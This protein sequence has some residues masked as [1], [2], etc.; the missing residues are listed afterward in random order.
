MIHRDLKPDNFVIGRTPETSSHLYLI[1]FG[2]SK[3]YIDPSN[4]EHIPECE[5]KSLTGTPRFASVHNHYG[6]EQSRRDDMESFFYMLLYFLKGKLP[7][8][9]L[10]QNAE[11]QK[12]SVHQKYRIIGRQKRR[13]ITKNIRVLCHSCPS[14]FLR[15]ILHINEL[16]FFEE[17]LYGDLRNIFRNEFKEQQFENDA[18][19]D[20]NRDLTIDDSLR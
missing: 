8:M 10:E 14:V 5:G 13:F 12:K 19:F 17:P 11:Y 4:S 7:W 6:H 16:N 3:R 15:T 20:W 2:L 18:I 9:S 1:D